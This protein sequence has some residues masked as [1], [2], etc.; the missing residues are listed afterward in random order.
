MALIHTPIGVLE[1]NIPTIYGSKHQFRGNDGNSFDIP[2]WVGW[3]ALVVG[4]VGGGALGGYVAWNT[5]GAI[6]SF[7]N[8]K[9]IFKGFFPK[10]KK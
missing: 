10:G 5:R 4:L 9:N 8:V 1:T 2:D 3:L 6:D 7:T